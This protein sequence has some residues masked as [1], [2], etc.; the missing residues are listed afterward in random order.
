M[1]ADLFESTVGQGCRFPNHVSGIISP[2]Q[3]QG[4]EAAGI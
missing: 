4:A 1:S 3:S 2:P